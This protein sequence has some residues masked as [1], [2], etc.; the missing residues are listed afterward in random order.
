MIT[1]KDIQGFILKHWLL[2]H[3]CRYVCSN[4]SG[5]YYPREMDAIVINPSG[6]VTEFEIKVSRSDF[7]ADF[8]KEHKHEC[9]KNRGLVEGD[10][11]SLKT[12]IPNKF[13]YAV[14]KGLVKP[15]EVPEYA[16][17]MYFTKFQLKEHPGKEFIEFTYEKK[18]PFIHKQKADDLVIMKIANILSARFILGC[19]LMTYQNKKIREKNEAWLKK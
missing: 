16:G 1:S 17:L 19:S 7:F 8:K 11:D 5:A 2:E 13:Y 14:P 15:E 18:A 10:L 12:K 3:H 6:Y 9:Y 4:F